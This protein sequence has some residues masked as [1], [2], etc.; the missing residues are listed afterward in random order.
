MMGTGKTQ[1]MY[2]SI[3][4]NPQ[5][6]CVVVTPFIST[7]E[8]LLKELPSMR[9]PE[10]KGGTKLDSLKYLLSHGFDIACTHSLFL[11]VDEEIWDMIKDGG[12]TL[13]ID[14]ALDIARPIN[15]LIDDPDY[16][17]KP[18]TAKFL[19][20]RNIISVDNF[21]RV[22]WVGEPEQDDYEYRY[23]ES[24][25]RGGNV[26]CAEDKLFLWMFP[27][28]VFDAFTEVTILSYL[29][30]GSV[31]DAY[32]QMHHL[33]YTLGS[34]T[35][36][37]GSGFQ[38]TGYYDDSTIRRSLKPLINLYDGKANQIGEKR[39]A[40][41]SNWYNSAE[42][43]DLKAVRTGFNTFLKGAKAA[44]PD[45]LLMWTAFVSERDR[46]CISG[47]KVVGKLTTDEFA[48]IKADPNYKNHDLDNLRCFVPCNCRGKNNYSDRQILAY[49]V[50]RFY[51]PILKRMFKN[52]Y[53]V[54]LNENRYALSEM[55][56]WIWR[57]RIRRN[58]L[59]DEERKIDLYV[60]SARMRSLLQKWL[61][62]EVV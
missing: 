22:S 17:V 45:S 20:N 14:E 55:I 33:D 34:V 10:Y 8:D 41:C 15:D 25:I 18:G 31:F 2:Q 48:A 19:I 61:D 4:D 60:P 58:A 26:F 7:I 51:N 11:N 1:A 35:G 37:Y 53:G 42:E 62:G 52:V 13:Y 49:L 46:L 23:L 9:Q 24:L 56:Q 39:T 59:P 21:G 54:S 30:S 6:S 50:N 12:Y 40:L 32:L 28:Q 3:R 38:F 57:S 29:F 36:Q 27:P 47:A 44:S 43:G 16:H 5:K